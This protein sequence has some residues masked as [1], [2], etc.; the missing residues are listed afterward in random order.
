MHL[1]LLLLLAAVSRARRANTNAANNANNGDEF[2]RAFGHVPI[3]AGQCRE[4]AEI[5]RRAEA[6]RQET[7]DA[8]GT[9]GDRIFI[10]QGTAAHR[11]MAPN[12][13]QTSAIEQ[14]QFGSELEGAM[15]PNSNARQQGQ[16]SGTPCPIPGCQYSMLTPDHNCHNSSNGCKKKVHNLCYQACAWAEEDDGLQFFCSPTCKQQQKQDDES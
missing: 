16:Q 7:G 1:L 10:N 11:Q 13:G 9:D 15:N 3:S 2:A 4:L 5:T 14:Q 6:R 12:H 8:A